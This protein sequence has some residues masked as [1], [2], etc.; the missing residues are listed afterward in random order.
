MSYPEKCDRLRVVRPADGRV[1]ML[2]VC[3]RINQ[4]VVI[5]VDLMLNSTVEPTSPEMTTETGTVRR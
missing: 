4:A 5:G 3:S 2:K 1:V